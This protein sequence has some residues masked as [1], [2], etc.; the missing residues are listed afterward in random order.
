MISSN[1]SQPMSEPANFGILIKLIAR[2]GINSSRLLFFA[3]RTASPAEKILLSLI[4]AGRDI[5]YERVGTLGKKTETSAWK[6]L[7]R[8][9]GKE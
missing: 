6:S 1:A 7:E 9:L 3:V 2:L 8:T 5:A 4:A